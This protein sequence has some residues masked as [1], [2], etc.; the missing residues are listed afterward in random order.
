M[1]LQDAGVAEAAGIDLLFVPAADE[2]YREEHATMVDVQ[3]PAVGLE[4]AHRPGHFRGVATVCAKLFAIVQPHAAFFGQKDAQQVAVVKQLVRDLN[5]DL[6][7]RVVPTE[8]DSDGLA[9]A[10][11]NSRL[12]REER[13]RARAV[14]RALALGLAAYRQ[15]ADPVGAARA[16]L[17]G[18][19]I[20]YVAVA[21]FDRHPTLAVAVRAG[22]TRLIDNVPLD[23][24][25]LAGLE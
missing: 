24:P 15:G 17:E 13:N 6:E 3:G 9:C 25:E 16:A 20:D 11:R 14:P 4:G 18:L 7:I 21:D 5:V 2:M 22:T 19:E 1:E 8:R 10:S 12:S 23:R